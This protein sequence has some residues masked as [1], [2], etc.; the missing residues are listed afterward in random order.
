MIHSTKISG[1]FGPKLNGSVKKGKVGKVSKQNWSISGG[2]PLF[3]VWRVGNFGW[4]DCA[5]QG[6]GR[7]LQIF[8]SQLSC[9]KLVRWEAVSP[10]VL[11]FFDNDNDNRDR[12][13]VM[14]RGQGRKER[15]VKAMSDSL[16]DGAKLFFI[17]KFMGISSL[18]A[19]YI[20]RGFHLPSYRAE[21]KQYMWNC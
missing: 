16:E 20:L 7:K 21:Y 4:M 18:I 9:R 15:G 13:L 10:S 17:K 1:N 6:R 19:R 5:L 12:S 2:G 3:P 8:S 11:L 14:E